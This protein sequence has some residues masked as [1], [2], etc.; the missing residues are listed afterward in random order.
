MDRGVISRPQLALGSALWDRNHE[1]SLRSLTAS[2]VHSE[3]GSYTRAY[4]G[5][6]ESAG[7]SM[8][9]MCVL[10]SKPRSRYSCKVE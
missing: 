2:L 6:Y 4:E 7:G 8:R 9:L 3:L 1:V 10:I 5:P